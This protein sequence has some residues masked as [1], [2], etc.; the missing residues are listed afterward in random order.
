MIVIRGFLWTHKNFHNFLNLSM[1]QFLV[2]SAGQVWFWA[3][4]VENM[5]KLFSDTN[6]LNL[7]FES[8]PLRKLKKHWKKIT[9]KNKIGFIK[10][11]TWWS[12]RWRRRDQRLLEEDSGDFR[13]EVVGWGWDLI[14]RSSTSFP[15]QNFKNFLA[16]WK[17]I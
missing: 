11:W 2:P 17:K 7:K 15:M 9:E 14:R 12:W 16:D 8:L 6:F 4:W 5:I 10:W 13:F 1:M 3:F